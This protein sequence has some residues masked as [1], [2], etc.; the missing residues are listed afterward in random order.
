MFGYTLNAKNY[1]NAG[2]IDKPTKVFAYNFYNIG[3]TNVIIKRRDETNDNYVWTIAPG[4]SMD[5]RL[6]GGMDL[7]Q[8]VVEFISLNDTATTSQQSELLVTFF[9]GI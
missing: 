2:L 9:I 5:T 8:Y 1:T 4:E 7:T 6:L 3:L